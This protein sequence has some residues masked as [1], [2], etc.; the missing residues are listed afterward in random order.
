MSIV[1]LVTKELLLRRWSALLAVSALGATVA[2]ALFF[3]LLARSNEG[4][5]R[6]L[7]R[8]MGLN[9][10]IL[11]PGTSLDAYWAQGLAPGSMPVEFLLELEDQGVANRLVPMIK[12]RHNWQGREVLLT[13]ISGEI[14][15]QGKTMKPVFGRVV[16]P[17]SLVLGDEI[18]RLLSLEEGASVELLGRTF[19]ISR[20]LAPVGDEQDVQVFLDL[21]D[22]Q[23]LLDLDGRITEIEA[24]ECHCSE[25]V[26]DPL[27]ALRVELDPLMPGAVIVRRE[28]LA[29]ARRDQRQLAG[30]FLQSGF[31]VIAGLC[32]LLVGALCMLNVRERREEIG[33]LRAL[34]KS[35][36]QVAALF[37][38]RAAFLGLLG[39]AT[40]VLLGGFLASDL[41]RVLFETR[42]GA[43]NL[44][45]D[46]VLVALFVTPAFA[47][48]ASLIPVALAV[49]QDPVRVLGET[50]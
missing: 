11:P 34:G 39:G 38:G 30:R 10:L 28:A 44:E 27:A 46:L 5:T 40:G 21:G 8:D 18:A 35:S 29:D 26:A 42:A 25:E 9:I 49:I 6:I 22:A 16:E 12:R 2:A 47:A 15:K 41:G 36:G 24:L 13:G 48:V 1:R 31:P 43:V 7:Q 23:S 33:V 14:F 50:S 4:E 20:V 37:L 19:G 32:A 17:G 45:L 3:F